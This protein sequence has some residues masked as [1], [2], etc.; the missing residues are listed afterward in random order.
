MS[1]VVR[2]GRGSR[3]HD[4]R[5]DPA[6]APS[7]PAP[8]G[9]RTLCACQWR[10]PPATPGCPTADR[11]S[12]QFDYPPKSLRGDLPAKAH[13]CTTT[14]RD[15]DD[16]LTIRLPRSAVIRRDLNRH[17]RAAVDHRL[18]Q[19]L[20]PPLEQLVAVHVMAPRHESTPTNPAPASPPRP[21]GPTITPTRWIT[22]FGDALHARR[23]RRARTPPRPSAYSSGRWRSTLG[24]SRRRADWRA[25]WCTAWPMNGATP[26]RPT[27]HVRKGWSIEPWR[28]HPAARLHI[29]S[30]AACCA[31]KTDGRRPFPNSRPRSP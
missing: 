25:Y 31:C 10:P 23:G 22:F 28:H 17:H 26:P 8:P 12:Q 20:P 1:R 5:T 13:P 30:K 3:T 6:S 29:P 14:K 9:C 19:Q 21:P 18:W 4:P 27:S 16:A 11:S 7:G 2:D 15:L 24:R